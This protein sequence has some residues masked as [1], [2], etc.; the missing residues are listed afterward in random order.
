[1]SMS[2]R[3]DP[4]FSIAIIGASI[5]G[6]AL[7]IGLR[8]QNAACRYTIYEAAPQFDAVGAGIWIGPNALRAMEL[9]DAGFA[10]LYGRIKVGNACG[11][12]RHEQFEIL[13]AA[14]GFGALDGWRGG[15]V[16]CVEHVEGQTRLCLAF[17]GGEACVMV[18]TV[19]GCDGIKGVTTRVVLEMEYPEEIVA[20]YCRTYVYRNI[21]P[22][23]EAKRILGS[24]ADNAKWFMGEGRGG[25]NDE[26]PWVGEQAAMQ[27]S[28]EDMPSDFNG[29][30]KRLLGLLDSTKPLRWPLFHHPDTSTYYRGHVCLLGDSAHA[31]SPSQAA[32]A[33]LG[34]EDA[35]V[36]SRLLGLVKKPEQLEGAF[37]V[38]NSIRQPSAQAVVQ[39]SQE[40]LLAY[41]LVHA[42]FGHDIQ[43]LTDYAN[44]RL[45]LIWF[46]ELEGD[47]KTAGQRFRELTEAAQPDNREQ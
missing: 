29:F 17:S 32:G 46:H 22:M 18:D 28:R 36:M 1:M 45:S 13:S 34:L 35:L 30:D 11:D 12:R 25:V 42:E 7:A 21:V 41:F 8:K 37:E 24:Y 23:Q 33:G 16:M 44:T 14:Q 31:S 3:L 5:A 26:R 38:Y 15:R 6:L 10:E 40:A 4:S 43:K 9:M 47:V 27:A 20:K 19:V 2:S 39:G